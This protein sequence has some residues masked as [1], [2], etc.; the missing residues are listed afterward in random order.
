MSRKCDNSSTG[1]AVSR[2]YAAGVYGGLLYRSRLDRFW[3]RALLVGDVAL[4]A[5]ALVAITTG[6][7]FAAVVLLAVVVG[8]LGIDLAVGIA[9]YRRV[10]RRRWPRVEPLPDDDD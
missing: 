3:A 1:E 2:R 4:V 8:R 10:M 7:T 5:G 6:A 9:G